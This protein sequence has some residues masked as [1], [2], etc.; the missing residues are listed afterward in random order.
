MK[1]NAASVALACFA[2]N[3]IAAPTVGSSAIQTVQ[4]VQ[5]PSVPAVNAGSLSNRN[6]DLVAQLKEALQA[7]SVVS[8]DTEL[9][10]PGQLTNTL[11]TLLNK[12]LDALAKLLGECSG[13]PSFLGLVGREVSEVSELR[14]I[15]STLEVVKR[16][17]ADLDTPGSQG[18]DLGQILGR[19]TNILKGLLGSC[20]KAGIAT[21]TNAIGGLTNQ[22]TNIPNISLGNNPLLNI[23]PDALNVLNGAIGKIGTTQN[24]LGQGSAPDLVGLDGILSSTGLGS[25]GLI[26]GN[27]ARPLGN[28]LGS[29]TGGNALTSRLGGGNL[30]SILS[31]GI[32]GP[33]AGL[34][35]GFLGGLLGGGLNPTG[36]LGGLLKRDNEVSENAQAPPTLAQALPLVLGYAGSGGP[37]G[38]LVDQLLLS[39]GF[40]PKQS[41]YTPRSATDSLLPTDKLPTQ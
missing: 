19:V 9:A 35:G 17:L 40:S 21:A 1:V 32:Y 29:L 10:E 37:I 24:P 41:D 11:Q 30:G 34:R 38:N 18:L 8:R 33:L 15:L 39:L 25:I 23:H 16:D 5:A 14:Q 20:D 2:G 22:L 27:T 3:V 4:S 6:E 12:I 13:K 28:T 31:L 36:L 7:T 26:G